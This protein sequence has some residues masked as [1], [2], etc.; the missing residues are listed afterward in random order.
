MNQEQKPEQKNHR[1][2]SDTK[3]LIRRHLSDPT[4]V[5]TEEDIAGVR[6]G[7]IP[8]SYPRRV[9]ALRSP[10]EQGAERK[11]DRKDDSHHHPERNMPWEAI[12]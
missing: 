7:M 11:P 5:I 4:H 10:E 6:I 2:E 1:F 3:K 8:E 9:E 12:E